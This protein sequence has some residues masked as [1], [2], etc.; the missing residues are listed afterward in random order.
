ME[1][2]FIEN[3]VLL[4]PLVVNKDSGYFMIVIVEKEEATQVVLEVF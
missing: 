1:Y 4:N 2:V 3:I